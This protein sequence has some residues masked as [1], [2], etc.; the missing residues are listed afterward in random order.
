[1]MLNPYAVCG[2]FAQNKM[3]Q[4]KLKIIETLANGYLSESTRRE[5]SNECQHGMV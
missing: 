5:L 1:M 4:E 3:M 2:K